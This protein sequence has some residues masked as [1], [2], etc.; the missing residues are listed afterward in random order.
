MASTYTVEDARDALAALDPGI[1]RTTWVRIGMAAHAAGLSV[2]D[3]IAWSSRA[4]NYDGERDCRS[5]WR[6]F[7]AGQVSAGTLFYLARDVGWEA[8]PQPPVSVGPMRAA[9]GGAHAVARP[10]LAAAPARPSREPVA[11]LTAEGERKIKAILA[12]GTRARP[13]HPYLRRKGISGVGL[14]ELPYG[15]LARLLGYRPKQDEIELDA[16]HPILIVPLSNGRG[17]V[18]SLEFID[19]TG[20]KVGMAR[21]P[22]AGLM[23]AWMPIEANAMFLGVAE[24]LATSRTV[25]DAVGYPVVAACSSTNLRNVALALRE[26][27]PGAQI[28]VFGD[29][30]NGAKD[31][32]EAAEAVAGVCVIPEPAELGEDG[33]DFN[34]AVSVVGSERLADTLAARAVPP[35]RIT[36]AQ[37][38]ERAHIDFVLPGL[39]AGHVGLLVGQGS[40]GKSFLSLEIAISL[41]LG[42][43]VA[44]IAPD[45]FP[46]GPAGRTGILFG[47]DD[48]A[49]IQNRMHS[50]IRRCSL[51]D[52]EQRRLDH[53]MLVMSLMADDLRV[54][55]TEGR[56]V[57]EGDFTAH[58]RHYCHGRRLMFVDPLIRLHDADE[59]DNTAA[60]RLMLTVSRIARDTGCAI[61]LLHHVGKGDRDGWQAA[62]G[63]SAIVTSARWQLNLAPPSPEERERFGLDEEAAHQFVKVAGA[64]M[65]YA[66]R[67][68]AS[69]WLRRGD[70]GVLKY[71]PGDPEPSHGGFSA[72]DDSSRLPA[73][74][75][76]GG[77]A[78][79]GHFRRG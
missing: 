55:K 71:W 72:F 27:A 21:V 37:A 38:Q 34:D 75:A 24:G 65:N 76:P 31:A 54:V 39:P 60:S 79:P 56:A 9:G 30:G 33:S 77:P 42:R 70:G 41:A 23:F 1:D 61:I 13:E 18:R 52:V 68:V 69:F 8:R 40:V 14:L 29:A 44:E 66:E 73:R 57:S 45:V 3:F 26:L 63:A 49:I 36:F 22:R 78:M 5:V 15:E 19:H 25:E 17:E 20:R 58:L 43:C 59:N 64:K 67:R 50:I 48:R 2:D 53:E 51:S 74:A 16:T 32:I 10:A 4:D 47:E 12:A 62:R 11:M 6:S 46:M 7:H 28:T 35:R